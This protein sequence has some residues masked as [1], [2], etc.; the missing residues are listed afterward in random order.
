MS[1][2]RAAACGDGE[3]SEALAA[4][5]KSSETARAIFSTYFII[6]AAV[7]MFALSA[8]VVPNEQDRIRALSDDLTRALPCIFFDPTRQADLLRG[9][10]ADYSHIIMSPA[11]FQ[12]L[13]GLVGGADQARFTDI[14]RTFSRGSAASAPTRRC[15]CSR[16]P[17]RRPRRSA[18][19]RPAAPRR[20]RT[21][22]N[23]CCSWCCWCSTAPAW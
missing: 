15:R 19:S 4:L 22:R 17:I 1:D 18:R 16:R 9:C 20:R 21:A 8:F 14:V 11:Q 6:Y 2:A 23:I 12:A 7:V 3:F 10:G 5:Q 13:R